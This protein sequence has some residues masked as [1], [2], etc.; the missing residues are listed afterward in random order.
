[1]R[2]A[3][4][5]WLKRGGSARS[6]PRTRRSWIAVAVLPAVAGAVLAGFGVLPGLSPEPKDPWIATLGGHKPQGQELLRQ[7]RLAPAR[8]EAPGSKDTGGPEIP[9]E[10]DHGP[11]FAIAVLEDR[12][13][14]ETRHPLRFGGI[15]AARLRKSF[16]EEG[17][18]LPIDW[19]APGD[20]PR[21]LRNAAREA[22]A[23]HL[24][25]G[26]VESSRTAPVATRQVE[27]W[28]WEVEFHLEIHDLGNENRVLA[29]LFEIDD[30]ALTATETMDADT[31]RTLSAR[32]SRQLLAL[33]KEVSEEVHEDPTDSE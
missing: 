25:L 31:L 1:M 8:E 7:R 20:P 3:L 12:W 21:A 27:G 9:L 18:L 15:C 22:G 26:R 10:A 2:D 5:R 14:D 19:N 32:H 23:T 6:I 30:A 13:A 17:E 29:R 4:R 24:I 28:R 11:V 33:W 16:A